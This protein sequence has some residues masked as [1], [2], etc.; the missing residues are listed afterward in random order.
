MRNRLDNEEQV[1]YTVSIPQSGFG[2]LLQ[3]AGGD[4]LLLHVA[5]LKEPRCWKSVQPKGH[6]A[7]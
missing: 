5:N 3:W 7:K 4:L 2:P 1:F 6:A